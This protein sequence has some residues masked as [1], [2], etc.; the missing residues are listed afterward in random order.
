MGQWTIY[1]RTAG[2]AGL[3]LPLVTG[4]FNGDGKADVIVTPMN[5]NSGPG[6]TRNRAGEAVVILGAQMIGG[7]R[8]LNALDPNMLPSDVSLVYG[9]DAFDYLGTE[10]FA[11]DLDGDG[12]D[13]T[14]LGAQHGDGPGNT[15]AAAGEVVIV[16]GGPNIGGQVIDT[17]VAPVADVNTLRYPYTV[18]YGAGA[19]DRLGVWVSAGDFNNDGTAD[20]LLGADQGDGPPGSPRTHA[21]ETAVVYGGAHLPLLAMIDLNNPGVPVTTIYG[22]DAEDHSGCTVRA[23]DMNGDGPADLLIGAGLNRLSAAVDAAGNFTGHGTGGGDGPTDTRANAGEAYVV[24]GQAN[25]CVPSNTCPA[26]IDLAAPGGQVVTTIYGVNANDAY[27]EEL[28]AGN[29]AGHADGSLDLLVGALTGDGPS[30]TRSNA[31]E[32]ALIIGDGVFAGM[33][34]NTIDL[35]TPP[36]NVTFFYGAVAGDIAG[37]TAMLGDIDDDGKDDLILCSPTASPGGRT[38]AGTAAVFFGTSAALPASI[39]LAAPPAANMP[40]MIEG[41]SVGD[42][43][44]YSGAVGDVNGDGTTDLVLNVMGGD[45][46]NDLVGTAGDAYVLDGVKVRA[47]AG[48]EPT[49]TGTPPTSTPSLS[50]TPI[51]TRTG[52]RTRTPT[53]TRTPTRTLRPTVTGTPSFTRRPTHT[54]TPTV[55]RT[56]TRRPTRTRTPTIS[57]TPTVT[58]TPTRTQPTRT[59][60]RTLRP[61]I[62]RTPTFTRRPTITRTPTLTR[63]PS[64]TQTPTVT[65]RPTFTRTITRTPTRTRTPTPTITATFTRTP[66]HTRTPSNTRTATPTPTPVPECGNGVTEAMEECDD[67]NLVNGDGCSA[68]CTLEPDGDLCT[69]IPTQAGTSVASVRVASGLSSP[70][71]VTAPPRDVSRL[72]IVEQTGRIRILKWGT[73]LATPFLDVSAKVSCCGERG[74]LSMAF[75]PNYASNGR[76]YVS[77]TNTSGNSVVSRFQVSVN[78]DI[79]STTETILLT[80]VQPFSNHNGG[81]LQFGPDGLLYISF[82]DGGSSGD[83]LGNGQ[84]LVTL[85]GKL[86]RIDVSGG[87]AYTVPGSNPFA[88]A[89]P[90]LDEIWAYGF[91]N[92]WRFSFDRAT[93]DLYTGDVG[94][95][96]FEEIDFQ[97]VSSP[98]GEN[99]GW[100]T[101]E[102]LHCFN[103]SSGCDQTG[104]TLPVVEYGHGIGCSVTGGYVYRGC[105]MPDLRGRYFYADYCSAFVKSF[106]ISAG[107]ATGKRDD[108]A[109]LAPG[110]GLSIDSVSSF[111]E[112]ARG[113]L[114]IV[115]L[116]GEVFK[117][118]PGP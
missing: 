97:P 25:T 108:T 74:L 19:G 38:N 44:C 11:G 32:A 22:I 111:G 76:F 49:P 91:R 104:L 115:D 26:S 58:R 29:F 33:A 46:F 116:G 43:L 3:G 27:G 65:P 17:A 1:G 15:R 109:E 41:N 99:Y 24:Y 56:N 92:P 71:Y 78:P 69:G 53:I 45:G 59:P 87:G 52:T 9:A 82:G 105:A 94:Q 5:A 10:V 79:A 7:E 75:D 37:D 118:V 112:D 67:G 62:T 12:Y 90:G 54:R 95:N 80:Q 36:S 14:M 6:Q 55:T 86:L 84:S 96:A 30:N 28:F 102:G 31:G 50:P 88:G 68:S 77:Y 13:D 39:D 70:V 83:P 51:P 64:A 16:W 21:G 8:N 93:G 106:V 85:L 117:M 110:G 23:A 107:V 34:S 48:H 18:I 2:G 114:Y 20:A 73:L 100:N 101:M 35:A 103:P 57:R 47:A 60:T 40:F 66:T 89:T 63:R 42:I 4:D 113:E 72:F 98:G 61:T 81:Q